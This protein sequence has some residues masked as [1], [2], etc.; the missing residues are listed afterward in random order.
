MRRTLPCILSALIVLALF[1]IYGQ[2]WH[3]APETAL[4]QGAVVR[5]QE[6]STAAQ[7]RPWPWPEST[8]AV[9]A[10]P[11]NHTIVLENDRV[12]VLEVTVRPGEKEPLHS[13]RWPSVL[14]IEQAGDFRDYDGEGKVLFDSTKAPAIT[15]PVTRWQE[16]QAP[17]AIENL[18]KTVTIRL[19]R[20]ELKQ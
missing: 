18:S 4:R 10:A 12:R 6:P 1:P 13:H 8:D 5:A 2:T 17:H 3:Q 7:H 9:V 11:G 14:H 15:Y 19:V 16:P 20:V